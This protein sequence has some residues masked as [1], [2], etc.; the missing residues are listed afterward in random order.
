MLSVPPELAVPVAEAIYSSA[1]TLALLAAVLL[2]DAALVTWVKAG[3]PLTVSVGAL[4]VMP[5]APIHNSFPCVVVAVVPVVGVLL[6]PVLFAALST[7]LAVNT[8]LYSITAAAERWP[9]AWVKVT[10]VPALETLGAY[11][12]SRSS[13]AS[14]SPRPWCS[15][16]RSYP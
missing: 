1:K 15:R 2:A 7:V 11:Q 12:I 13:R 8:P 14:R 6:L 16:L 9:L 3:L 5:M 4:L 10:V